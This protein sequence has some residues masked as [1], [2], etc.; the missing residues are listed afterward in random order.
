M[1]SSGSRVDLLLEVDEELLVLSYVV[2]FQESVGAT[3]FEVVTNVRGGP[4]AGFSTA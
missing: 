2:S 1:D 4:Q 3:G